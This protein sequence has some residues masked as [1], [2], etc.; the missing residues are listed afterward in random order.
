LDF[1]SEHRGAA[2]IGWRVMSD[3]KDEKRQSN[4]PV[5]FDWGDALADWERDVEDNSTAESTPLP[6]KPPKPLKEPPRAFY[7]P[8]NPAEFKRPVP[9]PAASKQKPVPAMSPPSPLASIRRRAEHVDVSLEFEEGEATGLSSVPEELIRAL[10]T[11]TPKEGENVSASTH[12]PPPV[13]RAS[14]PAPA[15]VLDID[16]MLSGFEGD[17][18]TYPEAHPKVASPTL[19]P[20]KPDDEL[21]SDFAS[22]ESESRSE[23]ERPLVPLP[24]AVRPIPVPRPGLMSN[25]K[26]PVPRAVTPDEKE[27]DDSWGESGVDDFE[28]DDDA[29]VIKSPGT[30]NPPL[31]EEDEQ[32]DFASE[33]VIDESGA[34]ERPALEISH[35]DDGDDSDEP[36][37]SIGADEG[38][39]D[40][41]PEEEDAAKLD[42]VDEVDHVDQVAEPE[43]GAAKLEQLDELV[44]EPEEGAAKLDQIDE[45]IVEPEEG[46]AKLDQID[47]PEEGVAKVDPVPREIPSPHRAKADRGAAAA[48]RSV[49]SRKP[50][51]EH[52]PFVGRSKAALEARSEL[53]SALAEV[54][55]ST[56][57]ARLFVAAAE[58]DLQ[59]GERD[60][61]AEKVHA[62]RGADSRDVAALRLARSFAIERHAL[63]DLASLLEAETALPLSRPER[64]SVLL[65]LAEVHLQQLD[66]ALAE[67]AALEAFALAPRSVMALLLMA[68][69][70]TAL[71]RDTAA[72]DALRRAG[73]VW[74]DSHVRAVLWVSAAHEFEKAGDTERALELYRQAS[75][76]E[77]TA[78]EALLGAARL[79]NGREQAQVLA[80]IANTMPQGAL[81]DAFTRRA[82][83]TLLA[84]RSDDAHELARTAAEWLKEVRTPSALRVRAAAALR[85]SDAAIGAE[86]LDAWAAATGGTERALALTRLAE[87]HAAAG[88]FDR[89]EQTL[90]AAALADSSLPM[91]PIVRELIVRKLGD[92][93]RIAHAARG[94]GALTASVRLVSD[95]AAETRERALVA[96]ARRESDAPL[97][98]QLLWLDLSA[99][100]NDATSVIEGLRA[101]ID[102]A[103]PEHRTGALLVLH[104]LLRGES[105]T[106]EQVLRE[107]R[108]NAPTASL[109]LRRLARL[110]AERNPEEAAALLL[111]ESSHTSGQRGAASASE[112]GQILFDAGKVSDSVSAYLRALDLAPTYGPA[113]VSL[114][115]VARAAADF[116]TLERVH[117][118]LAQLAGE[119]LPSASHLV[120]A[121]LV[122]ADSDPLA[123]STFLKRARAQV[124]RDAV[125]VDL[126]L[127]LSDGFSSADRAQLLLDAAKDADIG[128]SRA[129]RLSAAAAYEDAAEPARAAELYRALFAEDSGDAM[130]IVG[131]ERAELASG[132]VARVAERRFA[133]VRDAQTDHERVNALERLALLDME[134]REDPASAVLSLHAI[135]EV[136]P[137]HVPSLRTLER[138]YFAQ[139]RPF[140]LL[141]IEECLATHLEQPE[142]AAAHLRFA[143]RLAL[144]DENAEG[145]AAD[146]LLARVG[147][148]VRLDAWFAHRIAAAARSTG[149]GQLAAAMDI[150]I[151]A[152][153]ETPM[154]RATEMIRVAASLA[155][156]EGQAAR[157]ADMLEEVVLS[158]PQHPMAGEF[159][160]HLRASIGD[161]RKA[162]EAL[163]VAARAAHL[164]ERQVALWYQAAILWQDTVCEEERAVSA[165]LSVSHIEVDYLD[166]F[167]RLRNLLELREDHR[168]LLDLLRR[169][170]ALGGDADLL[171]QLG[172]R[173]A[174]LHEILGDRLAA[175]EALRA[176]L[177]QSPENLDS[178]KRFAELSLEAHAHRDAADAL[179]KIARLRQDR[180]E[181]HWVF[182]TLG[183]IYD[184]HIPDPKRAEAAYRRV[185]KLVPGDLLA[186]ERLAALLRR[187]GE[188]QGAAEQLQ[189]LARSEPDY[190]RARNHQL[191]LADVYREM[192]DPRRAEQVLESARRESPTDI[193]VLEALA[194]LYRKQNAQAALAIHANRAAGDFRHVLAADLAD[195]SAWL[196]LAQVLRWRGR[197]DAARCVAQAATALGIEGTS[198]EV[199]GALHRVPLSALN[200]TIEESLSP[201]PLP[202]VVRTVMRAVAPTLEKVLPFDLRTYKVERLTNPSVR[203]MVL[204]IARCFEIP[205]VEIWVTPVAPRVC[206]PVSSAP[207]VVLMIGRDL[208]SIDE[209]EQMFVFARALEIARLGLSV[210]VRTQP[211]EL[212]LL[213]AGLV[214]HLDPNYEAPGIDP[215]AVVEYGRRIARQL[216][217]R[218]A[219]ELGPVIFEMAGTPDYDPRRMAMASSELGNRVALLAA[220]SITA[221]L[222]ALLKQSGEPGIAEVATT[223]IGQV[224]KFPEAS[225]LIHFAI[226][227]LHFEA[228]SRT[229]TDRMAAR[230][231][232]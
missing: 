121:S 172:E 166:G 178:L 42:Q 47:E 65:A 223:R 129:L 215:A 175:R 87:V 202:S 188:L 157:A 50:R 56:A 20:T 181:L 63:A 17:T 73:D 107:A 55:E 227:E 77:P 64:V 218:A 220:G 78:Y 210:A 5:D 228:R 57:K 120:R 23:V 53:L 216:P 146:E 164:P 113:L 163:E 98:A 194:E 108:E 32:E 13:A 110:T 229:G 173:E 219:L 33:I 105:D 116:D 89:A 226:S 165:L 211:D 12:P 54:S 74:N 127:R 192:N 44:A 179:I 169:R 82:A 100:A 156:Q 217:R 130:A 80:A 198:L 208:L 225:A 10:S 95:R 158:A 128:L 6:Q 160:A 41:E 11:A 85:A 92:P 59:R 96:E 26:V 69:A 76:V 27:S 84:V 52:F 114:E 48:R 177:A 153:A 104:D 83:R 189:E 90:D 222:S 195:K 137:G 201:A 199:R 115:L 60:A 196:G 71:G 155:L 209:S 131:L 182:F 2:R 29:P 134:V 3:E 30:I 24:R 61:A 159:L 9:R 141:R 70:R 232:D 161:S 144:M 167:D 81:R 91:I 111:E 151:A 1:A 171:A 142:D 193:V 68:E 75:E 97:T 72:A 133:E 214:H 43:V 168:T 15:I 79:S 122:R 191:S 190:E 205:D 106:A 14:Q 34:F 21:N 36:L 152:R 45:L 86:A 140:D 213:M 40:D 145:D 154:V 185:L 94:M 18:R 143:T 101:E 117:E 200:E 180:D 49:R 126:C 204:E 231:K 176:V 109:V 67:K 139:N 187:Q 147:P 230:G 174:E 22:L 148:R 31:E 150:E 16:D 103:P 119:G 19:A 186:M 93:D 183:E 112:A 28:D 212:A 149:Q 207:H 170:I 58:L 132:E 125:L 206:V 162:A 203:S 46:V 184:Q 221:A 35:F 88:D 124:P 99:N 25:L 102:R 4:A 66:Y 197:E 7:R 118:T 37:I 39:E 138:Y 62:A 38:D 123:A 135:L 51:V 8:P 136:S 224:A